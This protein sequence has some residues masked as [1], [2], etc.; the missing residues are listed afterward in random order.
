V[1]AT[2]IGIGVTIT[3]AMKIVAG[4]AIDVPADN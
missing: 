2:T 1:S 4:M 3:I